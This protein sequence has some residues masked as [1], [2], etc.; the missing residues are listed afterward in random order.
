MVD[1][2]FDDAF[3]ES[4][5]SE[6]GLFEQRGGFGETAGEPG[7]FWVDV[8][9]AGVRSAAI[10]FFF[11]AGQA[12]REHGGE[13]EIRVGVGAG[14]SIFDAEGVVFA[15]DAE[16]D[17]AVVE[18]PGHAGGSPASGLVAFVTVDGWG[19]EKAELRRIFDQAAEELAEQGR[20]AGGSVGFG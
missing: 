12:G 7:Q 15:D 4:G 16:A 1:V 2:K 17:G 14:H 5:A 9:V 6:P 8:S 11:D 10:E 20:S 19:E 3:A 13:S 18:R